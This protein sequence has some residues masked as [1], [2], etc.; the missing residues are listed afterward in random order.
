MLKTISP[1]IPE[2]ELWGVYGVKNAKV[3]KIYQKAGS[4]GTKFG[5]RLRIHLGMDIG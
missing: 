3:W 5:T 1:S 4:I 2:G